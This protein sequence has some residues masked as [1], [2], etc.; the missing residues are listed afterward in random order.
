MDVAKNEVAATDVGGVRQLEGG[1]PPFAASLRWM[2]VSCFTSVAVAAVV[3]T[4][5]IR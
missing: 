5:V 1:Q 3:W 2:G 4:S